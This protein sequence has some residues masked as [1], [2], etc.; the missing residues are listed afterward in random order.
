MVP[1]Q[2]LNYVSSLL[3]IFILHSFTQQ[4]RIWERLDEKWLMTLAASMA[5][6]TVMNCWGE[7]DFSNHRLRKVWNDPDLR[8]DIST[9]L[10]RPLITFHPSFSLL[11]PTLLLLQSEAESNSCTQFSLANCTYLLSESSLIDLKNSYNIDH[12][13][14]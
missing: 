14:N 9:P 13:S 3:F 6:A 10:S 1:T 11:F 2:K 8:L 7:T 4:T 12:K 5:L